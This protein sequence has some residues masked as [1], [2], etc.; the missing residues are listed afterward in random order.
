M[1]ACPQ[2]G[3]CL[4]EAQQVIGC[5]APV[6]AM[7]RD[8][9]WPLNRGAMIERLLV[10]RAEIK[11]VVMVEREGAVLRTLTG[12]EAHAAVD[13]LAGDADAAVPVCETAGLVAFR[14][15]G[16]IEFFLFEGENVQSAL[17]AIAG[18]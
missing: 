3:S 5:C 8:C 7:C 13:G 6:W 10:G 14:R 2:C 16:R 15:A 12:R 18:R 11:T 1:T 4:P 9:A 17:S